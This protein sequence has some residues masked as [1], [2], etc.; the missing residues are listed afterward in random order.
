M[1]AVAERIR[2][3]RVVVVFEPTPAGREALAAARSHAAAVGAPLTVMTVAS[4]ERT[5]IGCGACRSAAAFHNELACEIATDELRQAKVLLDGI[6]EAGDVEVDYVLAR[7][8]FVRA[9]TVVSSERAATCV[10]VPE[11][12]T[13]APWRRLYR[14]RAEGVRRGGAW[15]V[16]VT[17]RRS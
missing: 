16:I 3:G 15:S 4:K 10:V 8:N 6:G 5:D 2:T 11:R 14:D 13:R 12:T 9:V 1:T 7:G 17:P